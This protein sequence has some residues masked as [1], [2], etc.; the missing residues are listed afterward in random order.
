MDDRARRC[1]RHRP[2]RPGH[3]NAP[4]ESAPVKGLR[5]APADCRT[6]EGPLLPLQPAP[7]RVAEQGGGGGGLSQVQGRA[8]DPAPDGPQ[9]AD[10]PSGPAG[11]ASKSGSF[12]SIS[13]IA[14]PTTTTGRAEAS[15]YLDEIAALIPPEVAALR[16]EDLRVEA[17]FLGSLTREPTPSAPAAERFR[18]PGVS[19]GPE[20]APASE[21]GEPS[22]AGAVDVSALVTSLASGT[23]A[24][25][26]MPPPLPISAPVPDPKVV[27]P[28]ISIEPDAI[29]PPSAA[30]PRSI[31]E[32]VLPASVVL[33]WSLF[34]LMAVPLAFVAGLMVGHY[35]WK[36][37]P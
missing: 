11:A 26:D 8:P 28:P 23:A 9:P 17:E 13:A 19:T 18:F 32:V 29:R 1:I 15:S 16:P 37:A 5:H 20:L 33:A 6:A 10:E 30:E 24:P 27:V 14:E 7:G 21:A 4:V 2:E 34:V 31:R 22:P 12:P 25:V 35:V 36:F 3:E